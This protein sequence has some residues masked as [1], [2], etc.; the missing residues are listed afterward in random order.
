VGSTAFL[1]RQAMGEKYL[2]LSY[3]IK[4]YEM[5]DAGEIP[6]LR[7]RVNAEYDKS[8]LFGQTDGASVNV[9]DWLRQWW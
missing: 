9:L 1:L 7:D 3:D 8:K 6:L 5:D 4:D 2:R